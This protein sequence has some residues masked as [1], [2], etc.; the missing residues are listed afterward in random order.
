MTAALATKD[1]AIEQL[2]QRLTQQTSRAQRSEQEVPS[3]ERNRERI[4]IYSYVCMLAGKNLVACI[5]G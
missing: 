2:A 3:A 4:F 1:A 5:M